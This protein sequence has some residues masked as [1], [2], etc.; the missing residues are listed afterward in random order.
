MLVVKARTLEAKTK[1]KDP[2]GQDQGPQG[3]SSQGRVQ[4]QGHDFLSS[5]PRPVLKDYITA[6]YEKELFPVW[7]CTEGTWRVTNEEERV[8]PGGLR[9]SLSK[10]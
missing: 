9:F 6:A 8:D 3:Q 2:Q 1:V 7:S 4:G 5:R 10:K